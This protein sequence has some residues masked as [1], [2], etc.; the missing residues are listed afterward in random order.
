MAHV[1]DPPLP[2]PLEPD[3]SE[4]LCNRA[5]DNAAVCIEE[6]SCATGVGACEHAI[7]VMLSPLL[8]LPLALA[9]P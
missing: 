1:L 5:I 9:R 8:P 2:P 4:W 3:C 7:V 6:G